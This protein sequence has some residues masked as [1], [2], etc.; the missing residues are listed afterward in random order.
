MPA[1][2][3]IALPVF[4]PILIGGIAGRGGFLGRDAT[5]VSAFILAKLYRREVA[6]TSGTVLVSTVVSFATLSGLRAWL[7]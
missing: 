3:S 2:L 1:V 4:G 5:G 6:S 7:A